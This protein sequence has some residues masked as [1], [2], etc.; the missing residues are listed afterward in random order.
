LLGAGGHLPGMFL[1]RRGSRIPD[2][3]AW[4]ALAAHSDDDRWRDQVSTSHD[5]APSQ[6]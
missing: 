2:F 6:D 3:V 4:L 1:V 5:L